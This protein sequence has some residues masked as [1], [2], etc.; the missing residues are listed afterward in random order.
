MINCDEI[1]KSLIND[2]SDDYFL[3]IHEKSL[4]IIDKNQD[5][6][7][8]AK[9]KIYAAAAVFGSYRAYR[10]IAK[11]EKD[12]IKTSQLKAEENEASKLKAKVDFFIKINLTMEYFANNVTL[13]E[14]VIAAIKTRRQNILTAILLGENFEEK[15]TTAFLMRHD[16][17]IAISYIYIVIKLTLFS[18]GAKVSEFIFGSQTVFEPKKI[19]PFEI[20]NFDKVLKVS[21]HHLRSESAVLEYLLVKGRNNDIS[22]SDRKLLIIIEGKGRNYYEHTKEYIQ[23]CDYLNSKDGQ[24][25]DIIVLNSVNTS[26]SASQSAARI[27]D[28]S[29]GIADLMS[30]LKGKEYQEKNI[31]LMGYCAGGPIASSYVAKA[32]KEDKNIKFKLISDRSFTSVHAFV[33]GQLDK[34]LS[35]KVH[36]KFSNSNLGNFLSLIYFPFRL[37]I[38]LLSLLL[39]IVVR[40]ILFVMSWDINAAKNID[41]FPLERQQLYKVKP[42]DKTQR[43]DGV[44]LGCHLADV[45]AARRQFVID[46]FNKAKGT[47]L[48]KVLNYI[49]KG[50][51]VYSDEKT[52]GGKGK[53]YEPHF[54]LPINLKSHQDNEE[55][56]AATMLDQMSYLIQADGDKL[57]SLTEQKVPDQ[58]TQELPCSNSVAFTK[59]GA[60][61]MLLALIVIPTL[62]FITGAITMSFLPIT[63]LFV[64]LLV[65]AGV[66]SIYSNEIAIAKPITAVPCNESI[67]KEDLYKFGAAAILKLD[68]VSRKEF[69]NE[70]ES[71]GQEQSGFCSIV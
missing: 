48:Q 62:G 52:D 29:K 8:D 20:D 25:V 56:S 67:A 41:S 59:I 42:H 4:D 5:L 60:G 63:L 35:K 65:L 21:E 28:L 11:S 47:S 23:E 32:Y 17:T 30:A 49:E 50:F 27:D 9:N 26:I 13:S 14:P 22:N 34:L 36:P 40:F 39:K 68:S 58:N 15:N 55:G 7:H 6:N 2:Q 43:E 10:Y 54:P 24:P 1:Y 37:V 18:W 51:L 53:P 12:A 70:L 19:T 69:D 57:T 33:N 61:L 45:F 44:V 31:T 3:N 66:E 46:Y 38:E 64:G 16:W 71:Y